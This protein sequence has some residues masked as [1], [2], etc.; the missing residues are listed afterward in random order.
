M[1]GGPRGRMLSR[2]ATRETNVVEKV[3][4]VGGGTAGW[5]TA[6]YLNAA[7]G[8]RL[9]VTVV[10][11]PRVAPIGVGEATFSTIRHFFA[12]LGLAEKDW[13]PHCSA[14]YKLA[15]R[16]EN[17]REPGDVFYHPF[18]RLGTVDGSASRTGGSNSVP[19]NSI[20]T[21]F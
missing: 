14:T 19:T 9:D 2:T 3:V 5:M 8:D 10:E 16:F 15:I 11:S 6:T 20:A 21:A 7:F 17:W 1:T 13:M 18:E 4:V 12:Y